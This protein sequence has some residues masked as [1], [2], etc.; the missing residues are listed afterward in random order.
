MDRATLIA[1]ETFWGSEG[2]Q[3]IRDLPRLTTQERELFDDLR[4]NR[5]RHGLRLEQERIGFGWVRAA[6]EERICV[7]PAAP[8]KGHAVPPPSSK[9]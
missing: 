6:L 1:H 4:D 8:I 7:S 2:D 5:I 3:V 9:W